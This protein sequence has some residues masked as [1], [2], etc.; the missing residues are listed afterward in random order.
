V[1]IEPAKSMTKPHPC[2]VG[3]GKRIWGSKAEYERD[4]IAT[5]RVQR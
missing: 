3:D 2:P 4:G 1:T 5:Q